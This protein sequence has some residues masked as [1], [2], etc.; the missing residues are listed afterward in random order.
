VVLTSSDGVRLETTVLRWDAEHQRMWTDAPVMISRDGSIVHG[1]GL[2]MWMDEE[3]T[4][5]HGRVRASFVRGDR[6]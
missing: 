3:T 5:V 6:R 1:T 4:T 2:E